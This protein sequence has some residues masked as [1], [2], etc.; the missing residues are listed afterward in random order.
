MGSFISNKSVYK[1]FSS[2]LTHGFEAIGHE[3]N[4]IERVI[5]TSP[6]KIGQIQ[7]SGQFKIIYWQYTRVNTI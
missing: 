4:V 1:I 3:S 2:Y 5:S 6:W 7:R